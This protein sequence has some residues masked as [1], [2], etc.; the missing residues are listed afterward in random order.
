MSAAGKVLTGFSLPYVALYN[1][2]SYTS[3]QKLAR[4]VDVTISPE[5]SDDNIFYADNIEAESTAGMFNGGT[6]DLTVDGLLTA[7]ESLI[8]GLPAASSSWIA[9]GDDQDI[10][11]VDVGFIAR[12]MSDGETTYVPIVIPKAKFSQIE[13]SAATQ[14]EEIDW[15]TQSLSAQ[16]YRADDANHTWKFVGTDQATEAAAEA[17]IKTKLGITTVTT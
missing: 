3:G 8:M 7:A 13:L 6:L 10:P 14:E 12:Y 2:G 1:N 4:G 9:Y 16:I 5:T 15:Q 17:L 11:F